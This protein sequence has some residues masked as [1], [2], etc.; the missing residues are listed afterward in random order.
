MP[1]NKANT[2]G[3]D[4]ARFRELFLNFNSFPFRKLVFPSRTPKGHTPANSSRGRP[5]AVGRL[6]K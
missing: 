3:W 2:D 5:Q 6:G 4:C 1:P